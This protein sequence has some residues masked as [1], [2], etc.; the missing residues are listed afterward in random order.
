MF[1]M[2]SLRLP[3][4]LE[5]LE[6]LIRSIS[7]CAREKGCGGKRLQEIE[8]ASEEALVNIISHAYAG[9]DSGDVEVTCRAESDT[10]WIIEIRDWGI[11]FDATSYSEPDLHAP[12]TDRKIGG[13]GIFLI[14]KLVD[15][16]KYRREEDRNVLTLILGMDR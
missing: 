5:N 8:L 11:P 1:L 13:L 10:A 2:S 15:E 3:A 7:V 6:K 9:E 4:K 14:R 16:I 12:I